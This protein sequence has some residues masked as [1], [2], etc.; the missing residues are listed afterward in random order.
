M[1]IAAVAPE[2]TLDASDTT[3]VRAAARIGERLCREA[4]WNDERTRCNWMGR[5]DEDGSP[6]SA[7][8]PCSAALSP[9][10]YSGSA[11]VALFLAELWRVERDPS[12]ARVARATLWQSIECMQRPSDL[13]LSPLSFW[14]GDVGGAWLAARCAEIG[15]APEARDEVP[16]LLDRAAAAFDEKHILD[17]VGGTAGAIPA[18]LELA[19]DP[20]WREQALPLAR[21]FGDELV[22]K[23]RRGDQGAAAWDNELA[24]GFSFDSPPLTGFSHGAA[25]IAFALLALHAATGD[26]RYLDVARGAFTYEDAMFDEPTGNWRDM[27]TYGQTPTYQAAWCHGGPGIGLGRLAAMRIDRER[28]STYTT[29]VRTAAESTR[30]AIAT[31]LAEDRSDATLCHGLAGLAEILWTLGQALGDEPLVATARATSLD[32]IRRYDAEGDYPTAAPL[33]AANPSFATGHAGIG[34]QF[35]RMAADAPAVLALE[36]FIG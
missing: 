10:L 20:E 12:L 27:R 3:L 11:G 22:E 24:S 29:Q 33:G 19:R 9:H 25:G 15:L 1:T 7:M 4:W 28:A 32:L 21:R 31:K 36:G 18:L 5:V 8:N 34:Y 17:V 14:V 2:E 6:Q 23:A 13:P 30:S 26:E 16:A 35:L